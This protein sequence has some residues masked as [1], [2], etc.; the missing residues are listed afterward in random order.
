MGNVVSIGLEAI[1]LFASIDLTFA[2][3]V[4]SIYVASD[5]I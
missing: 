1:G 3:A 5:S 2:I 4:A